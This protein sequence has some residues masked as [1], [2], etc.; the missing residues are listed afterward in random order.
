MNINENSKTLKNVGILAAGAHTLHL[1]G[2]RVSTPPGDYHAWRQPQCFRP[3]ALS[4][5]A[6]NPD[7]Y[8]KSLDFN[9]GSIFNT[10]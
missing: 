6:G 8:V 10:M 1:Q 7:F 9:V 4:K 5:V 3:S 2:Q